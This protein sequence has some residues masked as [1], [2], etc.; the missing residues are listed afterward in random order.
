M[1]TFF[2]K[3]PILLL[4]V[5]IFIFPFIK[6]SL[7]AKEIKVDGIVFIANKDVCIDQISQKELKKIFLAKKK[8]WHDHSSVIIAIY[9]EENAKKS[10]LKV[11]GKSK[12]QFEN[13]WK[14]LIFTGK[15]KEPIKFEDLD[16]LIDFV[17]KTPGAI[18]YI[19]ESNLKN[20]KIKLIEVI[21]K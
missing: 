1:K 12:R 2:L 16:S 17:A 4:L 11:I 14:K 19:P 9:V 10:F 20:E 6:I 15:S 21:E 18:S 8:K 7:Y 13:Y 3:K 5:L